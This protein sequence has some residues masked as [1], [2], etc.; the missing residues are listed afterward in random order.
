MSGKLSL[1]DYLEIETR[2]FSNTRPGWRRACAGLKMALAAGAIAAN[3][4]VA[5]LALSLI[6]C[7]AACAILIHSQVSLRHA[8]IFILAPAWA[9]LIVMAGFSIGFGITP[10]V[11]IGPVTVYREGIMEGLGAGA[12]VA[13]DMSWMAA[14][15]LTTPFTEQIQTLH[16][17]RIPAV[18]VDTL[19]FMYRYVFLLW[20]EFDRQM[21]AAKARG[22]W[23]G[24]ARKMDTIGRI[25]AQI[26]LQAYDRACRIN[27]S[28]R[29]RGGA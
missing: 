27:F 8:L 28:M 3:V 10:L 29:A 1:R 25:V 17:I 20:D 15:F 11:S 26:F 23:A 22:G 21:T 7:G 13:C 12:R 18:L 16:R 24:P 19:A 5:D 9:T 2:L 6:L 4:L 14:L